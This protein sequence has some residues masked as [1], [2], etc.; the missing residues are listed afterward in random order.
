VSNALFG[1]YAAVMIDVGLPTQIRIDGLRIEFRV[2]KSLRPEPNTAEVTL[3]N[4]SHQS[5]KQMQASGRKLTIEAGY[6]PPSSMNSQST[7]RQLFFGNIRSPG[8]ITHRKSENG[9]D[10]LTKIQSGDGELAFKTARINQSFGKGARKTDVLRALLKTFTVDA[11]DAIAKV[12]SQGFSAVNEQFA[13]GLVASGAAQKL[14]SE[15]L[16]S[17]GHGWSIQD[18]VMQILASKETSPDPAVVLN[19]STGLVGSPELGE[20]GFLKL[21]SVLQ[22]ELAPGRAVILSS[23]AFQG[24]FRVERV[25]HTG[26]TWGGPWFSECEVLPV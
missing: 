2:T 5:R 12:G 16:D 3:T 19:A 7:V 11:K 4:L 21:K 22:P 24:S 17:S 15:V 25:V 14:L 23:A 9:V 20:D 18:G 10:W 13:R 1:R 8:G 6:R 26:D